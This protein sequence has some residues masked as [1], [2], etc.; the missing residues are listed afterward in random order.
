M[1]SRLPRS[2]YDRS[3]LTVARDLLGARLVRV[4]DDGTRVSGRIVET[5]AYSGLDDL[6]SH[7][8]RGRT[9]RT[10]VMY[11][12]PGFGYVYF[13]Y[14]NWWMPNIVADKEDFPAAVLLRALEPLEGLEAMAARRP[15]RPPEEWT[16][17]PAK[18]AVALAIGPEFNG[19]DMTAPESNLWVEPD[20]TIPDELVR[21]GP[22]VGMGK[23]PEPW[24][25]IPWRWWVGGNLYVSKGSGKKG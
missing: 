24:Y 18:L 22:R 14:G 25:S 4:L 11:G 23:T 3:A 15:G 19:V 7:G 12:P 21:T 5:E 16:N 9:R 20:V 8:H 17:G 2:F 13:T 6:A 1:T 10:A